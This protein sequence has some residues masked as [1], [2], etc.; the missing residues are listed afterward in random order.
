MNWTSREALFHHS[1]LL[2]G[3]LFRASR[4]PVWNDEKRRWN[5]QCSGRLATVEGIPWPS[6]AQIPLCWHSPPTGYRIDL[7]MG[8][9][10]VLDSWPSGKMKKPPG[11]GKESFFIE[12]RT[13]QK[14]G[15]IIGSSARHASLQTLFNVPRLPSLLHLLWNRPGF[16]RAESWNN[17]W[18]KAFSTCLLS[19][20]TQLPFVFPRVG[21]A[22]SSPT[23]GPEHYMPSLWR[24]P[25]GSAAKN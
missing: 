2:L 19:C 24:D 7:A 21:L 16:A 22:L 25:Y 1:R 9:F 13:I 8:R 18:L 10:L 20:A 23:P 17:S 14:W 11:D 5:T 3:Y 15:Q 4:K 6:F 12:S